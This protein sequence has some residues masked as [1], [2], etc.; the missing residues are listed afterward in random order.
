MRKLV[1]LL[2]VLSRAG[3]ALGQTGYRPLLRHG[4]VENS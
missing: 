1:G 4:C 3:S 2:L